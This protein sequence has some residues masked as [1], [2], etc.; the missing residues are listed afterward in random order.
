MR[1]GRAE[2]DTAADLRGA[3]TP[4]KEKHHA[5]P[6]DPKATG[7]LLRAIDGYGGPS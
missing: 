5:S 3:L 7:E 6:T 4:V 1:G 2:R